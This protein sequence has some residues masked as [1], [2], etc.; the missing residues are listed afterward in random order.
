MPRNRILYNIQDLFF[1]PPS[2]E[3]TELAGHHILRRIKRVQSVSYDFNVNRTDVGVI[4]KTR[5][6]SRLALEPPTLSLDFNYFL[7]GVTNE[8][9]IG[10]DVDNQA[11][12]NGSL[13]ISS[14]LNTGRLLDSRNIYLVTNNNS[15]FDIRGEKVGYETVFSNSLLQNEPNTIIDP[16][17]LGYG[18]LVFQNAYVS[19]YS[20]NISVGKIPTVDV[21][22]VADNAIY[23]TSGSG[24]QVPFLN[25]KNGN[26]YVDGTRVLIPKENGLD[27]GFDRASFSP[28]D[29]TVDIQ[30]Q[31]S[32]GINFHTETLQSFSF[33][34]ALER[35]NI[36]YLGYKLYADRPLQL[37]V[38][39]SVKLG[40]LDFGRSSGS[41]LTEINRDD[42]Y[43]F[44]V[45]CKAEDGS[46]ALKCTV[47]GAKFESHS[48]S[49]SIGDNASSEMGF[50]VEMDLGNYSNGIFIS[51]RGVG[52]VSNLVDDLGN[53]ITEDGGEDVVYEYLSKF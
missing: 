20:V 18:V 8:G 49:S 23:F 1:G 51:G 48:R 3:A 45:N 30:K 47:S 36:S 42:T 26:S 27:V 29:M 25:L 4:G 7:E 16:E 52:Y 40:F 53:I 24:V 32:T 10:F 41:F 31:A 21:S 38:K 11:A 6:A 39:S 9:R 50:S 12:S 44:I 22:C 43:N 28:A 37:P 34:L 5:N 33:D 19:N 2:G 15:D 14:F 17:A 46:V 35:E 13:F